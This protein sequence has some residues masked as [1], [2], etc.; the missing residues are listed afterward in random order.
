MP[1][2]GYDNVRAAWLRALADRHGCRLLATSDVH[3]HVA[4]RRP[5]QDVLTC[6][7]S[8]RS[9]DEIGALL[10]PNSE[11]RMKSSAEMQRLFAAHPAAI[12]STLEI[13][14]RCRFNLD[15]LKYEY[16]TEVVRSGLSPFDDLAERTL[17]GARWRW[18]G[19]PPENVRAQIAH[20]FELIRRLDY[21]PYFLTI[22]DL[23]RFANERQILCQGRGSAANSAVC[24][25]LGIT[26][27]D[28]VKSGLL[29]ERFIS[30]ARNEP[31]RYRHRLRARAT[32][33]GDPV[34]LRQVWPRACRVDRNCAA[35][36]AAWRAARRGQ[37]DGAVRRR[38]APGEFCS[39][40]PGMP[41]RSTP[42]WCA[43]PVSIRPS[44]ALREPW[45]WRGRWSASRAI[46]RNIPAAS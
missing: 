1:L 30:A 35:L 19:E 42:T 5:L 17:E 18:R 44:R 10:L 46:S 25:A 32:R 26:A 14:D 9:I 33:R 22:H 34:C 43:R 41:K 21:A 13:V 4:G 27:V 37:G 16:P 23:V 3:Y 11:K 29:F 38:G 7:R 31:T 36:P 45:R 28:P 8:G 24:F 6:I 15:E 2:R 12:E 20:E 40:G 39:P